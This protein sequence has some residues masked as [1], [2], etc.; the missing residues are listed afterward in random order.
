MHWTPFTNR[1]RSG[2]AG[3]LYNLSH[4]PSLSSFF[5]IFGHPQLPDRKRSAAVSCRGLY[6]LSSGT[7][8]LTLAVQLLEAS[9]SR[10]N[11]FDGSDP[12]SG[13]TGPS[14]IARSFPP[15][16]VPSPK[17]FSSSYGVSRSLVA[18]PYQA[19]AP[20]SV[21]SATCVYTNQPRRKSH[22]IYGYRL[23][24]TLFCRM[25]SPSGHCGAPTL[26]RTIPMPKPLQSY[27]AFLSPSTLTST[28]SFPYVCLWCIMSACA[29][30]ELKWASGF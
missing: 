10:E 23:M 13:H 25:G 24:G 20:A 30:A 22:R 17:P 16:N 27:K 1:A 11:F 19:K 18:I 15:A 28:L 14:K 26:P 21:P 12:C 29:C 2:R 8:S 7:T 4:S 6:H 9:G 5:W 3:P